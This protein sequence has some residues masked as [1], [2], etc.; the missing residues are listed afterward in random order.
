MIGAAVAL[1]LISHVPAA[2]ASPSPSPLNPTA[3]N[4]RLVQSN[5]VQQ[6]INCQGSGEFTLVVIPGLGASS[7]QW[8]RVRP[9]LADLTR[10]CIYDRPS[11]GRSPSRSHPRAVI[12]VRE[13]A[14]ELRDLLQAA[15]ESG[16]YLV[17]GHSYGGLIAR[18]FV[19]QFPDRVGGL[20]LMEGVDPHGTARSHYWHEAGQAIDMTRSRKQAAELAHFAG[21]L[22]VLSASHPGQDHLTGPTYGD[23]QSSIAAWRKQQQSATRLSGNALWIVA[24]SGHVVQQ[25]N[26]RATVEAVR[27]L[28]QS[29]VQNRPLN[30]QEVSTRVNA[31]CTGAS[32]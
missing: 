1:L 32:S 26:P 25:D 30:C 8:S 14:Q 11:I 31:V 29:A 13:H 15:G 7:A 21:P 5:G 19:R 22:I 16:P 17:L 24:R 9:K 20:L 4:V 3:A 23:S 10:T 12:T 27:A 28:L 2:Q 6:W 18:S